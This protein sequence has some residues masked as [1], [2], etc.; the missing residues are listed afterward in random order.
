MAKEKNS[1]ANSNYQ[2]VKVSHNFITRYLKKQLTKVLSF[3]K[4]AVHRLE[5]SDMI[6][7]CDDLLEELMN[8]LENS[9][10]SEKLDKLFEQLNSHLSDM[11]RPLSVLTELY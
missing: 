10:N 5:I 2:I 4:T 1:K 3:N 9:I 7:K 6:D 11:S 8:D